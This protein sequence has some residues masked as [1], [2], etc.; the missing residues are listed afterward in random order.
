LAAENYNHKKDRPIKGGP[1]FSLIL[2]LTI[3]PQ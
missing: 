3:V 1:Y 2:N